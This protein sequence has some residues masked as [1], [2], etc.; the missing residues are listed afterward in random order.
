MSI[1]INKIN[2]MNLIKIF[3]IKIQMKILNKM[4]VIALKIVI[5]KK[6]LISKK[7]NLN[8]ICLI[9]ITRVKE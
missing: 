3:M 8:L 9:L 1:I 5:T 2:K 6:E 4:I 7:I